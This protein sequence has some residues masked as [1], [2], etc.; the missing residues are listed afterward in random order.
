[1]EVTDSGYIT[2]F[3]CNQ[4]KCEENNR[5]SVCVVISNTL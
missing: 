2:A 5:T 4:I 3:D 1:M